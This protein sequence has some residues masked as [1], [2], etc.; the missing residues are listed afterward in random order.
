MAFPIV[1]GVTFS[2]QPPITAASEQL[3]PPAST[4]VKAEGKGVYFGSTQLIV[5]GAA[6]SVG[7]ATA[8]IVFTLSPNSTS[9]SST[10]GNAILNTV[11]ATATGTFQQGNTVTPVPITVTILN[12]GTT[13]V[14]MN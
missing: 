10:T 6:G 14:M 7:T 11:T 1:E 3:V 8:P 13:K 9:C 2:Y 5:S 12:A 4:F